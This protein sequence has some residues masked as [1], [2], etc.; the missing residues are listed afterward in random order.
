MHFWRGLEQPRSERDIEH[1]LSSVKV[2]NE[3]RR[4]GDFYRLSVENHHA[5]SLSSRPMAENES[6]RRD[7]GE[8]TL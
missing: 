1:R 3:A 5:F 4:S 8:F 6:A 2:Q 7:G